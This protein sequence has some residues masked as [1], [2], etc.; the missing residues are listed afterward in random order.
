MTAQTYAQLLHC[1]LSHSCSDCVPCISTHQHTRVHARTHTHTLSRDNV[2]L[3]A[4]LLTSHF[5]LCQTRPTWLIIQGE[6]LFASHQSLA[7]ITTW[8]LVYFIYLFIFISPPPS[9][10]HF[11]KNRNS[12]A[13]FE[14][15]VKIGFCS[16][17]RRAAKTSYT[18]QRLRNASLTPTLPVHIN[19]GEQRDTLGIS[20]LAQNTHIL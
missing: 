4:S 15:E 17:F 11:H 14:E 20:P 16:S 3:G 6:V 2:Q 19:M 13:S 5:Y 18:A 7:L 1:S 12:S 9:P 10:Q 8:A